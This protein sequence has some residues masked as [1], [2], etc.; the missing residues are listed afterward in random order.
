MMMFAIAAGSVRMSVYSGSVITFRTRS[1]R[2]SYGAL[3]TAI[4]RLPSPTDR[5]PTHHTA[6]FVEQSPLDRGRHPVGLLAL[7]MLPPHRF[8]YELSLALVAARSSMTRAGPRCSAGQ[9]CS[10]ASGTS[11]TTRVWDG[12][13]PGG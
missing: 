12:D 5:P 8:G 2:K 9:D 6:L 3:S 7:C 13:G 11:S 10:N 4:L 1:F